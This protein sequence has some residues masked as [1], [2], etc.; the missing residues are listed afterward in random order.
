M[1]LLVYLYKI[2]GV[3]SMVVI[4]RAVARE[5]GKLCVMENS[6]EDWL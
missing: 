1:F 5:S 2:T 6:S 4:A 3:E